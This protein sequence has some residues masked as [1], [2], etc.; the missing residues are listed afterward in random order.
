MTQDIQRL[1]E[2]LGEQPVALKKK[3]RPT[4][5]NEKEWKGV[6]EPKQGQNNDKDKFL[7]DRE[8]K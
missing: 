1:Q 8:T 3:E 7:K 5:T 4:T 2:E 6:E